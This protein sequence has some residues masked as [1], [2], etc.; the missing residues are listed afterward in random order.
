MTENVVRIGTRK[1]ALALW[2]AEWIKKRLSELNPALHIELVKI[3]TKGD[4]IIDSPLANIGGKG[5]FVKEIEEALLEGRAD[6]AVHSMKDMPAELPDGLII[7]AVPE[8]EDPFDALLIRGEILMH[9]RP[10]AIIGTSSL[11]RGAQL[12]KLRPDA[13]IEPLRG[14]VDTRVRKLDEGQ[15][16]AVVLAVAGLKRMGL[17]D[18]IVEYLGPPHFLPAV[19]QGALAIQTRENDDSTNSLI[20]P[21]E[22]GPSRTT[23]A[24]ERAFLAELQGGCQVPIAAYAAHVGEKLHVAGMVASLDGST[25]LRQDMEGDPSDAEEIGK[26]LGKKLLEKGADKILEEIY[27]ETK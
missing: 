3:T 10:G 13:T 24:A 5:L 23:T 14:N 20:A 17:E 18:R 2:Q 27:G 21:L 22:H 15:Y 11:R 16:D 4:K 8:R 9:L 26:T 6:I 1:S 25:I 19:G 7:G 12:K